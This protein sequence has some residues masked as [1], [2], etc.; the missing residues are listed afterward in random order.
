VAYSKLIKCVLVV[1]I[2]TTAALSPFSYA[3]ADNCADYFLQKAQIIET[4]E[5]AAQKQKFADHKAEYERRQNNAKASI[6]E[7][8][9]Q[10]TNEISVGGTLAVGGSVGG[11]ALL[12]NNRTK[13]GLIMFGA[14]ALAAAIGLSAFN[15]LSGIRSEDQINK[16][17]TNQENAILDADGKELRRLDSKIAALKFL[18]E[19]MKEARVVAAGQSDGGIHLSEMVE[20]F[21]KAKKDLPDLD[22][23]KLAQAI[24]KW[25][26]SQVNC[27][28]ESSRELSDIRL[29]ILKYLS[30]PAA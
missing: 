6:G 23:K 14:A 11:V 3:R 2:S 15:R 12:K 4:T 5:F 8:K 24:V 10:A 9:D 7:R 19:M 26:Q 17:T 13:A 30:E 22:E 1:S 18:S 25:E 29:S 27:A 21:K 28:A 16:D 20:Q